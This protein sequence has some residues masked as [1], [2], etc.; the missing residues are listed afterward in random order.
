MTTCEYCDG[1]ILPEDVFQLEDLGEY[2]PICYDCLSDS[3]SQLLAHHRK[4]GRKTY[5][6]TNRKWNV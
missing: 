3:G 5:S 1:Q 6:F 2:H 4:D